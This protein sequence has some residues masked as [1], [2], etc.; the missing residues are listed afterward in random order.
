M[1]LMDLSRRRAANIVGTA[2]DSSKGMLFK[3]DVSIPISQWSPFVA[4]VGEDLREKGY[5]VLL[6]RNE[7][8]AVVGMASPALYICCFGHM[9]D[10]NLHLNILLRYVT[11][12]FLH[13]PEHFNNHSLY[14][15][16]RNLPGQM[17]LRNIM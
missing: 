10:E 16:S 3:Y 1:A 11:N 2:S 8:D 12:C 14:S 15:L 4:T 5:L 7:Y 9:G 13:D 17:M 6:G